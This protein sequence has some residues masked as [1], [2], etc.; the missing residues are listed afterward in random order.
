MKKGLKAIVIIFLSAIMIYSSAMTVHN[1]VMF[2]RIGSTIQYDWQNTSSISGLETTY[3]DFYKKYS[4]MKDAFSENSDFVDL[5]PAID[6]N[7]CLDGV[8]DEFN[9]TNTSVDA[10]IFYQDMIDQGFI[11][12]TEGRCID[13]NHNGED[14]IEIMVP[15]DFDVAVGDR[16]TLTVSLYDENGDFIKLNSTVVGKYKKYIPFFFP[17]ENFTYN[18]MKTGKY[19]PNIIIQNIV[20]YVDFTAYT[21]DYEKYDY[22]IKDPYD[23]NIRLLPVFKNSDTSNINL[24]YEVANNNNAT[25][26]QDTHYEWLDYLDKMH[27]YLGIAVAS[28]V[29]TAFA[30]VTL[31]IFV[32][33]N[34][35]RK[36]DNS[37]KEQPQGIS[38]G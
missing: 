26:F 12:I 24:L 13:I 7:V 37:V 9:N 23:K 30:A 19:E 18:Y 5:I 10:Y 20:D 1:A 4:S 31:I 6:F 38:Q 21:Y 11:E 2:M 15:S 25:V 33:Y 3:H 28:A 17:K 27:D 36:N 32:K 35:R 8:K 29:V 34:F 14:G 16:I 22:A